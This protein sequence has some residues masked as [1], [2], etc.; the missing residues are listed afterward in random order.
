[1]TYKTIEDF[2]G[3]TPLV[4]LQ[5]LGAGF[6][7]DNTTILAKLDWI[8]QT[9]GGS[10]KQ[11]TDILGVIALKGAQLDRAYMSA[12]AA[13]LGLTEELNRLFD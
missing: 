13:E 7:K 9:R 2:I 5:R 4:R 3:N 12:T 1:M 11:L 8:R 10:E 6:E